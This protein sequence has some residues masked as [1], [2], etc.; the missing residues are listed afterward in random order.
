MYEDW[1]GHNYSH[2]FANK[3]FKRKYKS[4][5]NYDKV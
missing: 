2:T 1:I 4:E 5:I 3:T